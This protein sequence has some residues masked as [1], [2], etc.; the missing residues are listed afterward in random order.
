M[1]S[2]VLGDA[3]GQDWSQ[4][5]NLFI[6]VLDDLKGGYLT[7]YVVDCAMEHE[8]L[9]PNMNMNFLCYE[10]DYFQPIFN[11]YK[12]AEIGVN[13]Y[14]GK[15]MPAQVVNYA[16]NQITDTDVR[17]WI[18]NNIPDFTQPLAQREDV[19][20]FQAEDGISKVYLFTAKQKVPPIY[21]ALS[22]HFRNRLR[23]AYVHV[24]S[25]IGLELGKEMGVDSW[26]TLLI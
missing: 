3:K 16:S 8:Q 23:F 5:D 15:K 11:L 25:H 2:E 21:K 13:P 20:D 12:P 18:T 10:R 22:Q 9:D 7:T 19:D 14:T 4:L 17:N 6:K 26:P 24:E 1:H